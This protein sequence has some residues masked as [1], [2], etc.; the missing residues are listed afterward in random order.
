MAT[1]YPQDW[2]RTCSASGVAAALC[3]WALVEPQLASLPL[4]AIMRRARGAHDPGRADVV[5][6]A[7]LRLAPTDPLA[8]RTALQAVL[9]R[10]IDLARTLSRRPGSGC[11]AELTNDLAALAWEELGRSADRWPGHQAAR[12]ATHVGR[13]QSRTLRHHLHEEPVA[14]LTLPDRSALGL[15]DDASLAVEVAD[16]LRSAVERGVLQPRAARI[17][18]DVA[19]GGLTD[20]QI[21]AGCGATPAAVK[22]ARQRALLA[23]RTH[24]AAL[25]LRGA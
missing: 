20:A 4:D 24:G 13:R 18:I 17:V 5:L 10:L 15:S 1:G 19:F 14:E 9:P 21:A 7:L 6:G 2:A 3:R 12:L 11:V 16:L 25:G 22:K 23:L 8:R